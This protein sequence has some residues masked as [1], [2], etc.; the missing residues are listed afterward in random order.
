MNKHEGVVYPCDECDNFANAAN[1][2]HL[3]QSCIKF[4]RYIIILRLNKHEGVVY[5]C[6]ECDYVANA[7]NNLNRHKRVKHQE[8]DNRYLIFFV[9]LQTKERLSIYPSTKE[10]P[11]HQ[12]N[13]LKVRNC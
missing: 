6:D 11:K 1:N 2:L 7:A 10:V 8:V 4:Y 9:Y 13:Q 12:R 3:Y 5:P